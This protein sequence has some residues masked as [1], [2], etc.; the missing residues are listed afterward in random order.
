VL[1][2]CVLGRSSVL[3]VVVVLCGCDYLQIRV[4]GEVLYVMFTVYYLQKQARRMRYYKPAFMYFAKPAN[5]F[6]VV[7]MALM[8]ASIIFWLRFALD[9]DRVRSVC[10]LSRVWVGVCV[11]VYVHVYVYVYVYVSRDHG[12]RARSP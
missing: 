4:L 2:F 7:F 6:E 10:S 5:M 9:P 12:M 8:V 11:Y 3:T 1:L